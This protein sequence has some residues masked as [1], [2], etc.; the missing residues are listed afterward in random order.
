MH[1]HALIILEN[2]HS[3]SFAADTEEKANAVLHRVISA[4]AV[5]EDQTEEAKAAYKRHIG[6]KTK[7][8][9]SLEKFATEIMGFDHDASTN[10]FGTFYYSRFHWTDYWKWGGRFPNS[11]LVR[12]DCQEFLPLELP[13][14]GV[15]MPLCPE[16][17]QWVAAAR[18]KDI[19]WAK[20]HELR[21]ELA[22][23]DHNMIQKVFN[24][25]DVMETLGAGWFLEGDSIFFLNS[26]IGQR[27]DT[28]AE[29]LQK[30]GLSDP[31]SVIGFSDILTEDDSFSSTS[32]EYKDMEEWGEQ[33]T[34]IVMDAFP[35]DILVSVD[36]HY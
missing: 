15:D 14:V 17:Y 3:N 26:L 35:D 30:V 34:D 21:V 29:H 11:I 4:P 12:K 25:A 9:P 10:R 28:L 1:Y 27:G 18:K 8:I 33:L 6:K 36:C 32:P 13:F 23:R 2:F 7:A 22:T 20:M 19:Q 31:E 5:F 24:G 16:G